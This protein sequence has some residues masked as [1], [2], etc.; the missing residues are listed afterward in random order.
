MSVVGEL[1]N[2]STPF[3]LFVLLGLQVCGKHLNITEVLTIV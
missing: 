2:M 3:Q 1:W